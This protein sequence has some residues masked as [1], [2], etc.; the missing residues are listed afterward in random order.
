MIEK[1][2]KNEHRQCKITNEEGDAGVLCDASIAQRGMLHKR[3]NFQ[4]QGCQ[5]DSCG[6]D[7]LP[8][9]DKA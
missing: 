8:T 3:H 6:G 2:R 4:A 1:S 5:V 9:I 7:A